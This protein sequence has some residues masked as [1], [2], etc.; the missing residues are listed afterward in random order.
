MPR[1]PRGS[2][3]W[4]TTFPKGPRLIP[5]G[6]VLLPG[7]VRGVEVPAVVTKVRDP[8]VRGSDT[9]VYACAVIE[10]TQ[11]GAGHPVLAPHPY[12]R[13]DTDF[14][15]Q[16]YTRFIGL[17]VRLLGR[18]TLYQHRVVHRA[19]KPEGLLVWQACCAV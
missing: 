2:A 8:V 15:V 11:V 12:G 1:C 14:R 19:G 9:G 18:E 3:R 6:V 16:P 7:V 10:T 5:L 17:R 4:P 13:V